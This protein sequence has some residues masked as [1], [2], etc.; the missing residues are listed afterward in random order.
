M[1]VVPLSWLGCLALLRSFSSSICN[2][3]ILTQKMVDLRPQRR[4]SA[5]RD[6]P[7]GPVLLGLLVF[8]QLEAFQTILHLRPLEGII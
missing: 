8:A 2:L 6:G 4:G 3:Q 1:K 5:P 7:V